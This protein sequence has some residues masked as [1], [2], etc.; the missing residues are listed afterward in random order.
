MSMTPPVPASPF[1]VMPA[2]LASLE[3]APDTALPDPSPKTAPNPDPPDLKSAAEG[4]YC[5]MRRLDRDILESLKSPA[6]LFVG[7][8]S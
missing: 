1:S 7:I 4:R 3:A 8:K 2:S 5:F 6:A